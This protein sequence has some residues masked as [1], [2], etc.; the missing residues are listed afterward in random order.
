MADEQPPQKRQCCEFPVERPDSP[1]PSEA[2]SDL[3][4]NEME[5]E[6]DSSESG[7]QL[8]GDESAFIYSNFQKAAQLLSP[9]TRTA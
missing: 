6:H 1:N 8:T 7:F 5:P 2:S 4:L 9:M 3:S